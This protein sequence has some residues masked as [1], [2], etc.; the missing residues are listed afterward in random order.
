MEIH[1]KRILLLT[2]FTTLAFA[3]S[4]HFFKMDSLF[5]VMT[6]WFS[7]L[8]LLQGAHDL[9]KCSSAIQVN[10]LHEYFRWDKQHNLYKELTLKDPVK[11]RKEWFER[12]IA[13]KELQN[14]HVKY[15]I[16][17]PAL[18]NPHCVWEAIK[19]MPKKHFAVIPTMGALWLLFNKLDQTT[20]GN[21]P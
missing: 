5:K 8:S 11:F 12:A 10:A 14:E 16:P 4:D 2:F 19:I 6:G 15:L 3:E 21:R 18:K 7:T 17:T 1:M 20:N 9:K 13:T